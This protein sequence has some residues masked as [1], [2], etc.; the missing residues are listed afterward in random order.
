MASTRARPVSTAATLVLHQPATLL[1]LLLLLQPPPLP[2]QA[3]VLAHVVGVN[4]TGAR[5]RVASACPR[6]VKA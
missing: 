3:L 5:V 1:H 2:Q 4:P 6:G